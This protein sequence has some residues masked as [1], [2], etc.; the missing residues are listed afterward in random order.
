MWRPE[1]HQRLVDIKQ[2]VDPADGQKLVD[3]IDEERISA[4]DFTPSM[5]RVFLDDQALARCQ[6]LRLVFMGG[7]ALEP[8]LVAAFFGR[9][10]AEL[11]NL[12]G[13][14]ETTVAVTAWRC[15]AGGIPRGVVPIGRPISNTGIYV[16]DGQGQPVPR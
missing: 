8:D 5:L 16:L 9:L 12:Y 3:L 7:E 14:A 15:R 10:D 6:S 2:S 13:P 1:V 4:V 11:L